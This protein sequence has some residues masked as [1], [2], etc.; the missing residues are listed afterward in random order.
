MLVSFAP[1]SA[2][3]KLHNPWNWYCCYKSKP[4]GKS[5][6]QLVLLRTTSENSTVK[7]FWHWWL[8]LV[9]ECSYIPNG[10]QLKWF[11]FTFFLRLLSFLSNYN[12]T[13]LTTIFFLRCCFLS[14]FFF[15]LVFVCDPNYTEADIPSTEH[16]AS[17]LFHSFVTF[18]FFCLYMYKITIYYI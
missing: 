12:K 14:W 5:Q 11:T 3:V 9:P 4:R 6:W 1:W 8:H 2:Q 17:W 16:N 13:L 7:C 18:F 10:V 15:S